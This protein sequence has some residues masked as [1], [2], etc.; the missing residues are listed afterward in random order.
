[1]KAAVFDLGHVDACLGAPRM[2]PP[3]AMVYRPQRVLLSASWKIATRT[4][5]PGELRP[6]VGA[7][8]VPDA[9]CLVGM[10]AWSACEVVSMMPREDEPGAE[11]GDEGGQAERHG[12]ESVGAA[13]GDAHEQGQHDRRDCR[14][15]VEVDQVVHQERR[16]REDES[17]GQ[18][19][20]PADQQEYLADGDDRYRRGDLRDVDDVVLG[21]ETPGRRARSRSPAGRP[22]RTRSPRAAG[23]AGPRPVSAAT[24]GTVAEP[25][26]CAAG[27]R[28]RQRA[29]SAVSLTSIVSCLSRGDPR[30]G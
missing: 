20:L 7:D 12:D 14:D 11:R 24:P 18:V 4:I 27:R 13:Y 23:R 19:D 21:E 30:A 9:L 8:P 25:G 29:R 10:V 5:G 16:E 28:H 6:G 2:L 22:R 15:A 3:A 26:C 1:M 17:D